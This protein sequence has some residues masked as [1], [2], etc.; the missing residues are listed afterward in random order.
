MQL[1]EQAAVK[2]HVAT[3]VQR[4]QK[5]DPSAVSTCLMQCEVIA[6]HYS[7]SISSPAEHLHFK[8]STLSPSSHPC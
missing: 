8:I 4:S 7:T 3:I 2:C 6:G 1:L 5:L